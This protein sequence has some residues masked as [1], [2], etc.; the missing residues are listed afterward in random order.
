MHHE[1]AISGLREINPVFTETVYD[2]EPLRPCRRRLFVP[3][4]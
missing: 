1:T 3:A 2:I 4:A